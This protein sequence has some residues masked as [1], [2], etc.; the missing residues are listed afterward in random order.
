MLQLPLVLVCSVIV[1]I[2]VIRSRFQV[3][4]QRS[5]T[6]FTSRWCLF[7]C[8]HQAVYS[9]DSSRSLP[10]PEPLPGS[11]S[12]CNPRQLSPCTLC[13]NGGISM[14][15]REKRGH[16]RLFERAE[17]ERE[18]GRCMG[19]LGIPKNWT[20][21]QYLSSTIGCKRTTSLFQTDYPTPVLFDLPRWILVF[22]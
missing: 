3:Y 19:R 18:R 2:T 15:C 1:L 11:F 21:L 4:K 22:S 14:N 17:K 10:L 16:D 13:V 6:F 20:V 7:L 9:V 12:L 8:R 5:D